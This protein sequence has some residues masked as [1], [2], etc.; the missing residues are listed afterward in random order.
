MVNQGEPT[1]KK[2]SDGKEMGEEKGGRERKK[3]T[4]R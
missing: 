1:D 4:T 3:N 2:S